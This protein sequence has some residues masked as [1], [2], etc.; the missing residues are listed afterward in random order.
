MNFE[1]HMNE[2]APSDA[3]AFRALAAQLRARPEREPSPALESRIL[4]AVE[5]ERLRA[6]RR[7]R[8]PAPWWKPAAAAAL[9]VACFYFYTGVGRR[10][11]R[12]P[13][14]AQGGVAWLAASQEAD[15]T[16]SPA[17][18]GGAESYRPALTALSALAPDRAAGGF[19]GQVGQACRA[20][21]ALQGADGAFGGEGRPRLYNQAITTF[22]LATLCPK[23][24]EVRSTLERALGY[25]GAQQTVQ[26]GWDYEAGSEGNAALTSWLVRA[27]AAAEAQ[28]FAQARTPLRK[29][30]RWLRG[31]ARDDGSIAY[32]RGSAARSESL[33]ALAA[34]ALI[35]SSQAY[36][37]LSALGTRVA[38]SLGSA[39]AAPAGADCYRDYAEVLAFESAGA[40]ERADEVRRRMLSQQ[41][42][43]VPDQWGRVGGRLYTVA[44]TALAAK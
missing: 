6:R 20:L 5:E 41:E 34:Y 44:L 25:V 35:T 3:E 42:S 14:G 13:G 7:F 18:H 23:H 19:S 16:W 11:V 31:A 4:A 43:A 1:A 36:P 39:E 12:E 40:R 28:G 30:L 26:G 22:A 8:F 24:P 38:A 37:E 29:G 2:L 21:A 27:L 10:A 15:G 17:K 32:H 33:T 9:L